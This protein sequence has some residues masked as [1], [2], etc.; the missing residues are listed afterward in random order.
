MVSLPRIELHRSP[1]TGFEV[2]DR[3]HY[4]QIVNLNELAGV[5]THVSS[6]LKIFSTIPICLTDNTV[7]IVLLAL[8][9]DISL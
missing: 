3:A 8:A 7:M 1:N 4:P 6:P 5:E 9:E 2:C